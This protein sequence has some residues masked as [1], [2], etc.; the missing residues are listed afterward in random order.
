MINK[1]KIHVQA[2]NL[3][4]TRSEGS[5]ET[6]RSLAKVLWIATQNSP[7]V[8]ISVRRKRTLRESTKEL[9]YFWPCGR[10]VKGQLSLFS[11]W[12]KCKLVN[13]VWSRRAMKIHEFLG[14]IVWMLK[15]VHNPNPN[16]NS[17]TSTSDLGKTNSRL[18]CLFI[19]LTAFRAY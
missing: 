15:C 8:C 14:L 3:E 2:R 12:I 9:I 13:N 10:G 4:D 6:T 19:R 1:Y 18:K 16:P 11:S 5:L 17:K 7:Q